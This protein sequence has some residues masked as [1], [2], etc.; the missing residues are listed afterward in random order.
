MDQDSGSERAQTAHLEGDPGRPRQACGS[1]EAAAGDAPGRRRYVLPAGAPTD[2]GREPVERRRDQATRLAL[3][4]TA[5]RT[6]GNARRRRR[7]SRR[8]CISAA[9]R[10][11]ARSGSARWRHPRHASARSSPSPGESAD[12]WNVVPLAEAGERQAYEIKRLIFEAAPPRRVAIVDDDD[13]LA[14]SI[15][16]FLRE[17]GLDAISYRTGEHL[18]RPW[19]PRVSTASSSTGC[20]VRATSG[21]CCPR[22]ATRSPGAPIIILTGQIKAGGAQEDELRIDARRLPCAAVREA[23]PHA[24]PL[25]RARPRLRTRPARW[26]R[27]SAQPGLAPTHAGSS[28]VPGRLLASTSQKCLRSCDLVFDSV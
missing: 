25:H 10:S 27:R 21:T 11:P 28:V 6:A 20:W 2:D 24:E 7:A 16:Q 15:V 13:D 18:R 8:R 19:R 26:L 22:C 23:D 14:A 5:V 17:K 3:R 12:H 4:R 9:S 1:R